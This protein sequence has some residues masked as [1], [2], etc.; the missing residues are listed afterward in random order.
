[1]EKRDEAFI[2]KAT[3]LINEYKSLEEAP[4][5]GVWDTSYSEKYNV[6][7]EDM[8]HLLYAYDS[9]IPSFAKIKQ[10][11]ECGGSPLTDEV[12]KCLEYTIHYIN[13]IKI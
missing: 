10:R 3:K 1:M 2:A 13:D 11:I 8:V 12:L 7:R 9:N 5:N 6:L 4:R